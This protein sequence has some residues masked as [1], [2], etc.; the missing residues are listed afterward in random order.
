MRV[1][2]LI[3][4][5]VIV[6]GVGGE[7]EAQG[8]L[9]IGYVDSAR[10]VLEA[11]G[12]REAEAEYERQMQGLQRE[13]DTMTAELD[14][15]FAQYQQQQAALLPN[16]RQAR[17]NEI[18]QRETRYQERLQQIQQEEVTTRERLMAPIL[19]QI[20]AALE[21]VRAE[22]GWALIFDASSQAIVAADDTLDLSTAV[23]SRLQ[24]MA[25]SAPAT[26]GSQP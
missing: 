20:A 8:A 11:P 25:A 13:L 6:L 19:A 5:S 1:S 17:E 9:K 21:A 3:A 23:L 16:I 24:A 4:A 18:R 2:G 22:G 26:P 14:S 7:L 10:I 12:A 15:L